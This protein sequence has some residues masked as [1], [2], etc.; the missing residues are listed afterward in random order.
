MEAILIN[1]STSKK[2]TSED[3]AG[4]KERRKIP[5]AHST[6]AIEMELQ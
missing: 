2:S 5:L 4:S 1:Y 6:K 3:S